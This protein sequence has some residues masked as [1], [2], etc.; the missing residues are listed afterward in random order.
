M[1]VFAFIFAKQ[2]MQLI[3]IISGHQPINY[4]TLCLFSNSKNETPLAYIINLK[5]NTTVYS[6]HVKISNLTKDNSYLQMQ[7]S[8]SVCKQMWKWYIIK[9]IPLKQLA[10][11]RLV[12]TKNNTRQFLTLLW[13]SYQMHW[14]RTWF[15]WPFRLKWLRTKLGHEVLKEKMV[16]SYLIRP[17]FLSIKKHFAPE[18]PEKD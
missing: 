2:I 10:P 17:K 11:S 6:A 9:C 3:Q 18:A 8:P 14:S 13:L 5:A 12:G 15:D 1:I 7:K 4:A 16:R